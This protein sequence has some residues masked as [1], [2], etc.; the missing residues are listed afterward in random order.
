MK[1]ALEALL[2]RTLSDGAAAAPGAFGRGAALGDVARGLGLRRHVAESNLARA[3]PER[4]QTDRR[5]ILEEHYREVGRVAWEYP[6]LPALVAAAD[7]EVVAEVRG[8][9]NLQAAHALGRGVILLTGHY[10]N[11]ELLG[12]RLGRL[13]PVDFVVKPLSNPRVEAMVEQWRRRAGVGSI[14]IGIGARHVFRAL[15]E[16]RWIAMLADQDA[17]GSGVFVPFF[18]TQ[19]STPPGPAA[20]ALRTGAPIVM[21]FGYRRSDGRHALDILPALPLP[22]GE[23]P[24]AVRALTAAHAAALE[25]AIRLRPPMW[26]WLHRRWKTPPPAPGGGSEA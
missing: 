23:G 9:E 2:V 18:G 19:T 16:R 8:L 20:F 4:S 17:R 25:G 14:P 22:P 26:F 15:R 6:R 21:G 3:F 24:D 7:G 10:G 5:A 1:H 12:A 11:F 13:N